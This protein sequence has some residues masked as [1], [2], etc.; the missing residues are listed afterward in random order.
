MDPGDLA[1]FGVTSFQIL[2][3]LQ[4]AVAL[5]FAALS[6]AGN[7]A[8]EKDRR[9]LDLLLLTRISNSE[10]VVGKLLASLLSVLTLI[11]AA[12]PLFMLVGCWGACRSPKSVASWPWPWS[13]P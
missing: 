4:L 12:L 3:P 5:F 8:A 9:T 2:A 11:V 13:A 10:L 1:R 7:V 6:S